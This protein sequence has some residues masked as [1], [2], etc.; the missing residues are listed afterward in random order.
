MHNNGSRI[1]QPSYDEHMSGWGGKSGRLRYDIGW[2]VYYPAQTEGG[3][4]I[5]EIVFNFVY[6]KFAQTLQTTRV[7]WAFE[8]ETTSEGGCIKFQRNTLPSS[9]GFH[10]DT[11]SKLEAWNLGPR[12]D[13][14]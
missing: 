6:P 3:V 2:L 11:A 9:I 14:G 4:R 1:D 7:A 8:Q 5:A 10:P 13:P 12:L